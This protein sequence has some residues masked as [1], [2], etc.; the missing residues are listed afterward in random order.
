MKRCIYLYLVVPVLPKGSAVEIKP[1]AWNGRSLQQLAH[2]CQKR[3]ELCRTRAGSAVGWEDDD[4]DE[5]SFDS[6][7]IGKRWEMRTVADNQ[8]GIRCIANSCNSKLEGEA[9]NAL[10]CL[11]PGVS[12]GEIQASEELVRKLIEAAYS[13][14]T[15]SH[16]L[17]QLLKELLQQQKQLLNLCRVAVRNAASR[18]TLY[19]ATDPFRC[20]EHDNKRAAEINNILCELCKS[21]DEAWA[22]VVGEANELP[23]PALTVVPVE[24]CGL[25]PLLDGFICLHILHGAFTFQDGN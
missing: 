11:T 12:I 17:L 2:C 6:I 21:F 1:T 14:R 22:I 19:V 20:L 25:D 7:S 23:A 24:K 8:K 10:D 15:L 16:C 13:R 5:M 9:R 4:S 18:C 3:F